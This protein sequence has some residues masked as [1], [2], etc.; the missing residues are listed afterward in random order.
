MKSESYKYVPFKPSLIE[1]ET[2]DRL[3]RNPP[4]IE[5]IEAKERD[6]LLRFHEWLFKRGDF[7]MGGPSVVDEYLK[8]I[9]SQQPSYNIHGDLI[10]E[11][12]V[13]GQTHEEQPHVKNNFIPGLKDEL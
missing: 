7:I 13:Y 1:Q 5:P 12:D 9:S 10:T 11:K 8:F 6:K 4:P 2:L 3:K